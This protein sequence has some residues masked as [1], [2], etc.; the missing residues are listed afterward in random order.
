MSSRRRGGRN[1]RAR[2]EKAIAEQRA[3]ESELERLQSAKNQNERAKEIREFVVNAGQD[4]MLSED[5]PFKQ[6]NQDCSCTI[7]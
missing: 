4:P 5:N 2:L 7:L 1:R 6:N 3:L